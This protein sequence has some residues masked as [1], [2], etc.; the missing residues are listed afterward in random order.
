MATSDSG[1][2]SPTTPTRQP[3]RREAAGSSSSSGV[4][5]RLRS[6][7]LKFLES[8]PPSGMWDATGDVLAKAP[9]PMEIRRGSFSHNGWDGP[10]QRRHTIIDEE[11][12]QRLSLSRSNSAQTTGLTKSPSTPMRTHAEEDEDELAGFFGRERMDNQ[13]FSRQ[14]GKEPTS[15]SAPKSAPDP[16]PLDIDDEDLEDEGKPKPPRKLPKK[17]MDPSEDVKPFPSRPLPNKFA[18]P[19]EISPSTKRKSGPPV[20]VDPLAD[21]D[22][23]FP[24]VFGR[25]EMT[26]QSFVPRANQGLPKKFLDPTDDAVA[27]SKSPTATK[28]RQ[29]SLTVTSEKPARPSTSSTPSPTQGP[30]AEGIYP[31]AE[32]IYPNAEGIYPNGY[33][34]PPKHTWGEATLIGLKGFWKFFITPLGFL[35]TIYG[36]NVIAW[37]GMLFLLLIGGGSE[38]MCYPER[39]HGIKDCNDLYS[40][41]RIWIE[42]DSQILNALFC[43]TGFGLIPWRFRDLYYLLQWRLRGQHHALRRLAGINRGWLRLPGSADLPVPIHISTTVPTSSSLTAE[44]NPALPLPVSKTPDEPLTGIRAPATKLW[45]LDYVIWAYVLNTFLQAV[46]SGFM[47]GLDRF[48]RPSWSTGTFVAM[49]C[50]VA[51]LGGLMAF[52]EGKAVKRVEGIP[53]EEEEVLRDLEKGVGGT[54]GERL[55]K[56]EKGKKGDVKG[57]RWFLRWG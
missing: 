42:I 41:R 24:N 12:V 57:L 14:G 5:G 30:N 47:W 48:K 22:D 9:T 34:F 2:A 26:D 45:K 10:M 32:G 13:S 40:P 55:K 21:E 43:V 52:N 36:L 54:K 27:L 53:V 25:G 46:L 50:I 33:K 23:P 37:G 51:G 4:A 18:D 3:T 29:K 44:H 15:K 28:P 1:D 35:I 11:N 20:F 6:A 7:S 19:P 39:L 56:G 38:Y 17:F 8:S 16:Y 31:N 49:A